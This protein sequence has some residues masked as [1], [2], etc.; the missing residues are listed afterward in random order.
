[1]KKFL[2]IFLLCCCRTALFAL[3]FDGAS[4]IS[5][6]NDLKQ[7]NEWICFRKEFNVN[8]KLKSA[9]LYIG[10]DSKYWLWVNGKKIAIS[11]LN[12]LANDK[13]NKKLLSLEIKEKQAHLV[14]ENSN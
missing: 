11:N 1:M 5:I 9:P 2:I 13:E 6:K 3:P 8:D 12:P 4:W 7:E 14:I 10:V